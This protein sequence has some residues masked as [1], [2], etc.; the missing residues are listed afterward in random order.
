[1]LYPQRF[2]YHTTKLSPLPGASV[3]SAWRPCTRSSNASQNR[4][5]PY[6]YHL[7]GSKSNTAHLPSDYSKIS[8]RQKGATLRRRNYDHAIATM[9]ERSAPTATRVSLSQHILVSLMR[10][11][12]C[13]H[14]TSSP[15]ATGRV[16]MHAMPVQV[17]TR[18]LTTRMG[19][20][21]TSSKSRS[22][23]TE[24]VCVCQVQIWTFTNLIRL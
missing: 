17:A 16:K 11:A 6:T 23:A 9:T 18:P 8:M 24:V 21:T 1:M 3:V 20:W 7:Y 2:P 19:S 5:L 15:S 4:H 22:V 14:H 13:S 10:G 12:S